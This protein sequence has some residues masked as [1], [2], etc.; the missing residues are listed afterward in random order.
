MCEFSYP[1]TIK[2]KKKKVIFDALVSQKE[3]IET[4]FGNQLKW[5]RLTDKRMSRIKF[6]LQEVTVFNEEDWHKMF[7]FM[8]QH[9]PRFEAAFKKPIQLL[10]RR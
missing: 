9:V 6:E 1:F 4:A 8:V 3:N 5:E 10:S 7:G 2:H